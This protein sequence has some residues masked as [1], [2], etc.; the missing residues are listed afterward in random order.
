MIAVRQNPLARLSDSQLIKKL[1]A[2]VQ[3]E[4]AATIEVIRHIIDFDPRKLYLG[5]GYGSLY[6]YCTLHLG[7]SKAAAMRRIQTARCIIDFPEIYCMLE[8]NELNLTG[9]SVLAGILTESNKKEVLT[10][11]R[12]KSKRQIE[13]IAARYKPGRISKTVCGRFL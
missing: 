9:V 6:D 5:I 10:T 13:E 1:D 8:K 3:K 12:C 2:L 4:R 11:A 7:F